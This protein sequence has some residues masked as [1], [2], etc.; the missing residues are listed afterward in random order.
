MS[1]SLIEEIKFERYTTGGI[2]LSNLSL[3][4]TIT[5]DIIV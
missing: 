5:N 4:Q 1:L 3:L 2:K